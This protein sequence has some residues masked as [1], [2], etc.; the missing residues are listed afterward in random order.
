MNEVSRDVSGE[1]SEILVEDGEN[2][3]YDEV[4]V[5]VK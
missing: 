3:E 1:V 5:R 2:V 4:V